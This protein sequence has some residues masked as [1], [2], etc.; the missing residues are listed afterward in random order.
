V[1]HAEQARNTRTREGARASLSAGADGLR[2]KP[3]RERQDLLP[4][5]CATALPSPKRWQVLGGRDLR[6]RLRP[7]VELRP[8]AVEVQGG[9]SADAARFQAVSAFVQN[10]ATM[11]TQPATRSARARGGDPLTG[12]SGDQ[13]KLYVRVLRK[14]RVPDAPEELLPIEPCAGVRVP[15]KPAV[16]GLAS[17]HGADR[18]ALHLGR[19][20][21]RP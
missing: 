21:P 4:A 11:C 12:V 16:G 20:S 7:K 5:L 8:S 9:E 13:V 1:L 3:F 19:R 15:L 17:S 10:T 2:A 6:R 14:K 18:R